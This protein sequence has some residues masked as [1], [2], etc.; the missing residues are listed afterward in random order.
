MGCVAENGSDEFGPFIFAVPLLLRLEL[1]TPFFVRLEV[2]EAFKTHAEGGAQMT[3][4]SAT[5]GAT[6][7][8]AERI[9]VQIL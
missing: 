9:L 7:T 4:S 5:A 1:A 6:T 8:D 2:K 3:A